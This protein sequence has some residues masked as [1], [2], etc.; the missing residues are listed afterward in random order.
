MPCVF[1]AARSEATVGPSAKVEPRCLGFPVSNSPA[2]RFL[3][4]VTSLLPREVLRET[5]LRAAAIDTPWSAAFLSY[6][7]KEARVSPNAF[8]FANAHR[9]Y[10]ACSMGKPVWI[11]IPKAADWRW[12]ETFSFH[13]FETD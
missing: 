8:T 11:M 13:L 5:I 12:L 1:A 10:I 6:V 9:A 2:A 7:M 3:P 4:V